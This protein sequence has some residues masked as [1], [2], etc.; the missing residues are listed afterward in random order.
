MPVQDAP[1]TEADDE[2]LF[3]DRAPRGAS[4]AQVAPLQAADGGAFDH[5]RVEPTFLAPAIDGRPIDPA[6]VLR[7]VVE[8]IE[9]AMI[10]GRPVSVLVLSVEG[11]RH[12]APTAALLERMLL[13][14]GLSAGTIAELPT[15]ALELKA[16]VRGADR[17]I[18]CLILNG[19]LIS[20][21]AG[22]MARAATL[23]ILVASDDLADTRTEQAGRILS[24]CGYFIVDPEPESLESA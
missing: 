6:H 3:Q 4:P 19:G 13:Q 10:R 16:L 8:E 14:R 21:E 15:T 17:H 18:D 9:G 12:A 22:P 23:T 1:A 11:V 5:T 24:G 2:D 20:A 7:E